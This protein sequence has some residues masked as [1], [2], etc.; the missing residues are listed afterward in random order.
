MVRVSANECQ[1]EWGRVQDMALAE[2]VTITCKGRDRMVLMSAEE[3]SRL[4]KR[5]RRVM[6]AGD[7][8]KEDIE[9]LEQVRAPAEASAFNHEVNQ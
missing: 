1:R 5:D 6:T 9:A 4:R 3:Y 2:P 7:F 8:T